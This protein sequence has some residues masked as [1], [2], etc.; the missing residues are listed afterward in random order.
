[1]RKLSSASNLKLYFEGRSE[2]DFPR[3]ESELVGDYDKLS[4]V[5]YNK[6]VRSN[7]HQPRNERSLNGAE[8]A[9]LHRGGAGMLP[10]GTPRRAQRNGALDDRQTRLR[11]TR[12]HRCHDPPESPRSSRRRPRYPRPRSTS[13]K[14]LTHDR[15]HNG[16]RR[17]RVGRRAGPSPQQRVRRLNPACS[18]ARSTNPRARS[19]DANTLGGSAHK[20][21]TAGTPTGANTSKPS[22]ASTCSGVRGKRFA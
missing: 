8:R 1:M 7:S 14:P 16:R 3:E 21:R 11:S 13:M 5:S 6:G 2:A 12:L 22:V 10:S 17:Y 20:A 9:A 19:P 15:P 4:S 18:S